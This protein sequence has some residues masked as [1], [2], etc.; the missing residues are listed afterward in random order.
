MTY[1]GLAPGDYVFAV[2]IADPTG[3]QPSG[4]PSVRTFSVAAP[5]ARSDAHARRPRPPPRRRHAGAAEERDRQ[6]VSGKVLVK[7]PGGKFVASTRARR[8]RAARRSTS[9]K[10][11]IELTAVLK[12]GGKPQ[13]ATFFDGIF[14]ITLGKKTTD[15]TLSQ[16][17]AKCPKKGSAHAA[18]AKRKKKPKTR[19]LWGNGSGSFR[20]RGQYSAATV[21]GTEWL[22]QDSCAGTLT[23]VK[24]GAVSVRDNVRRRRSSCAPERSTWRDRSTSATAALRRVRALACELSASRS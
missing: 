21:R 23:R 11:K 18:A 16:A 17:L 5:P 13:T 8:S 20:T 6:V 7:L 3:Q 9:S 22:V 19:K 1:T 12:K 4:S 24:K 14:K 15:L 2:A 10:G